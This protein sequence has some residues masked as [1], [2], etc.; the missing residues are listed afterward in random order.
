MSTGILKGDDEKTDVGFLLN[1]I[2]INILTHL[3]G[4]SVSCLHGIL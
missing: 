4:L 1:Y 2:N 3:S